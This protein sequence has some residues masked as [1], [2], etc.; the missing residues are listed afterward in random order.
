MRRENNG[1]AI[2]A[3]PIQFGAITNARRI[4]V[5]FRGRNEALRVSARDVQVLLGKRPH[6]SRKVRAWD[7]AAA[8]A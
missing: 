5:G 1:C 7:L 6:T 8:A 4:R 3:S 2:N